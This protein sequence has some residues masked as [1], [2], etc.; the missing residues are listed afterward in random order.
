[1]GSRS[2][3]TARPGRG[4]SRRRLIAG[5]AVLAAA[6]AIAGR[7][8]QVNANAFDYPER[9]YAMGEWVDLDGAFTTY[10]NENTQGYSLCVQDAQIMTRAE[11]IER[12]ALDP[13][14]VE[15]T[16][17]DDV[18]SVL[19]LTLAIKNEGSDS[20]GFYI[21][22]ATL[23]PEGEIRSMGLPGVAVGH[24]ERAHRRVG[25]LVQPAQG[26]R[27]HRP[28]PLHPLRGPGR[29]LSARD[30]RQA[31]QLHRVE[32]PRA[33]RHRHRGGVREAAGHRGTP[34]PA[35]GPRRCKGPATSPTPMAIDDSPALC[36][37]CGPWRASERRSTPPLRARPPSTTR[38]G[39]PG[40]PLSS[41]T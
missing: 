13:S 19:C 16:D 28:D 34:L 12:Y 22:D 27:V 18:P 33:Q 8:W 41:R 21:Y 20:G 14:Q 10:V 24:V 9:H 7:I 4:I 1:M 11:Y 5:G 37:A 38:P 2:R 23:V 32:R 25:L 3:T 30:P 17:Y 40:S 31:L 29:G 26:L 15:P 6:A 39:G 36:T 35:K